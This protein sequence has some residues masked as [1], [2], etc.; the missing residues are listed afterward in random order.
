MTLNSLALVGS[1]IPRQCGIGTF[2]KDL[3]DALDGAGAQRTMVLAMDDTPEGYAYPDEVRFQ[4]RDGH[5]QDY[6]NAADMLNINQIDLV[7]VQHEFGIFGGRA[8]DYLLTLLRRLRMPV[9][10]T[11]HTVLQDPTPEQS[12]VMKE[13]AVLSDRIVVMCE[14]G[15]RILLDRYDLPADRLAMIPH[16]IP[17][18][19]FG[20]TEPFKKPLGLEGRTV[21]LTFGLLSPDKGI[22]TAIRALPAIVERHPDV[23]YLVLGATHP[24]VLRSQ[25]GAYRGSLERLADE[26][27]VRDHVL[28]HN[29]YVSLDELCDYLRAADVYLTPYKNAQQIV[30]G[31]LSYALGAG[32]AVVSTPYLY[33]QEL[34]AEDRG[35]L[36]PFSDADALADEVNALLD[37]PAALQSLRERAYAH[38]RGMVWSEV[39][40]TYLS[41]GATILDARDQQP[42]RIAAFAGK[43]RRTESL[44]EVDITHLRTLTDDTGILQHAIYAVPNRHHGYCTDDNCRALLAAVKYHDLTRDNSVL[45]LINTYLSFLHHALN[46]DVGRFRNFMSYDRAWLEEVGSEDVHGRT[47]WALGY[48]VALAPNDSIMALASSLFTQALP[49]AESLRNVRAWAFSIVGIHAYLDRFGGDTDARRMRERLARRLADAFEEHGAEDWPWCENEATYDNAKLPHALILSGQWLP[50]PGMVETGLRALRWLLDVQR[51]DDG[52]L[53]IIGNDGWFRRGDP[54]PARFDQQAVDAMS[55]V[56]ACAE[57]YRCTRDEHWMA[58]ADRCL[59]WFL[60]RNDTR[61]VLYDYATGGCF[62]G[63]HADGPNLNQG[64]EST[65]AWLI[66]LLTAHELHAAPGEGATPHGTNTR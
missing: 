3:R 24:H 46:A 34:L 50:D 66:A 61:S 56:E 7:S 1:Y 29:R 58:E 63:L 48:A 6:R 12:A 37:D 15:R 10:T 45:P 32:K 44:P 55:L 40:R 59:A 20:P 14:T 16:G 23:T 4:I 36:F 19:A 22:E 33:A 47:L 62:D 54:A 17:D 38:G 49:A 35:R 60:G 26:L 43:V 28:F 11:L 9:V 27:G 42:R 53:S 39:A 65:L 21:V 52:H 5:L 18:V 25:G 8:G 30:S 64:A 31:T 41:L 2:T 51:A 57:A 13:L